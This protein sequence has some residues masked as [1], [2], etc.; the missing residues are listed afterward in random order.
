MVLISEDEYK[1]LKEKTESCLR[2]KALKTKKRIEHQIL[3]SHKQ[4]NEA[5]TAKVD[6]ESFL[7]PQYHSQVQAVLSALKATGN[8]ITHD[9]E[10]SLAQGGTLAGSDI[11]E[12]MKELLVGSKQSSTKPEGWFSFLRAIS[13]TT[14]PT[15]MFTKTAVRNKIKQIRHSDMPWED[16]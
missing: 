13:N 5:K 4:E 1:T 9:N 12:L 8:R 16:Y 14:L 6:V 3:Q 11:V 15:S 2:D 10:L 7:T